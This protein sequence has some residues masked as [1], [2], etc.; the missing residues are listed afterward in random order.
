MGTITEIYDFLRL[1]FARASDAYSYATGEKMVSYTDSQIQ[2]L[3]TKEY[4]GKRINLLA[5]VV[6][7]KKRTLPRRSLSRLPNKAL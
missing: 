2:E 1:L 4:K 6:Q 7:S 3:I 5:P